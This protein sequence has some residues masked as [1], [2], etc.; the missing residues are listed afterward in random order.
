MMTP[1]P[2]APLRDLP[3][4]PT[5]RTGWPWAEEPPPLP[6]LM[7][8]GRPWPRIS[9][10][11][12]SY[13]QA[14][15]LEETI[16]S[17]LLQGYP[18]LEYLVL[19]G[20]SSDGSDTIIRRYAPWLAYWRSERDTGQ[21]AAIAEG[22]RRATGEIMAYLNSD[23]RYQP[24]A[25]ARVARFF[26]ANPR[27]VFGNGDFNRIDEHG[28]LIQRVFTTAPN[29]FLTAHTA[30]HNIAQPASFWRRRAYERAGGVD[31]ALRFCMDRDLFIRIFAQ[32]PARRI[33]GPPL[34]DFREHVGAKSSTILHVQRAESAHLIAR[35]G[36]SP[37]RRVPWLLELLWRVWFRPTVVRRRL[38]RSFGWEL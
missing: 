17:V 38:T 36:T 25:L 22:L 26:A 13:N 3:P 35:Y 31:P 24:G 5:G 15:F 7:P 10:V 18:N 32:G 12:P 34:A 29:R 14:R 8:D 11:T 21:A 20:G 27:A 28:A 19:D 1:S 33:P 6:A 37:L 2:A 30:H 9:I 4:P 23:D 16:R